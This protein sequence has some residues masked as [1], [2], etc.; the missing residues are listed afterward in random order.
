MNTQKKKVIFIVTLVTA[1]ALISVLAVG[2][3]HGHKNITP[4]RAKKMASWKIEDT[5]DKVDASDR[6][7][8]TF[9]NAADAVIDDIFEMKKSHHGKHAQLADELARETP[10]EQKILALVDEHL[11]EVRDVAHNSVETM[12]KAWN[13][14]SVAQ[15]KQLIAELEAEHREMD[16]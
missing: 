11:E 5:L 9:E 15:K 12:L 3:G 1:M 13:T 8:A 16:H 14:L 6:Q 7:I 4:E 2:C 10:D